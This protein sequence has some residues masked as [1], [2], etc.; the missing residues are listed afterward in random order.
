MSQIRVGVLRGGVSNE[1]E[2]SL[3]VGQHILNML[4]MEPLSKK[5]K[6]VD[7]LVDREGVWHIDGI[8]QTPELALRKVDVVFSA[9]RGEYGEDGKLQQLLELFS[10]PFVGSKGY[11]AAMAQNKKI[12]KD[13]FKH[14][15]I[16]TPYYKEFHLEHAENLD[17]LAHDLFR[18]FPMP[19]VVKP[20]G[21]GSSLGVSYASNVKELIEALNHARGFSNEIIVEE[22]LT[23]KEIISGF[24]DGFRGSDMYHLF[25]VEVQPHGTTLS[26]NLSETDADMATVHTKVDD[27]SPAEKEIAH[28]LNQS[29]PKHKIFDWASKYSGAYH[30]NAPANLT[31]HEK[32]AILH[33]VKTI[34][35]AFG[36]RHFATADFIVHPKRGV[37]LLEINAHPHLHE[38]SP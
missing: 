17:P 6:G 12:A 9:L 36:L 35:H 5:Y 20:K 26:H 16:K 24:I 2:M 34:K 4:N 3:K 11:S 10:K 30:H 37:Y 8:P 22:Y 38:H 25:P 23:G 1:Y 13:H 29:K 27:L 28:V 21:Q 31:Q 32:D 15:G 19:V 7:V 14:H 33:A 18:T